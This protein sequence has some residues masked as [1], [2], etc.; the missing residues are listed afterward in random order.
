MRA[1]QSL[2]QSNDLGNIRNHFIMNYNLKT[3]N[4]PTITYSQLYLIICIL[5]YNLSEDLK[6]N[7]QYWISLSKLIRYSRITFRRSNIF[8]QVVFA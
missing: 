2:K 4:S 1:N 6:R 5:L 3:Q 7:M 8:L